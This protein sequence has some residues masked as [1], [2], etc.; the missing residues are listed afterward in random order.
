MKKV[1]SSGV[2]GIFLL[3]LMFSAGFSQ[4]ADSIIAK[5]LDAQGGRKLL[6][7]IKDSTSH[8]EKDLPTMGITGTVIMYVK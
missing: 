7:S 1:L 2:L 8:A 6:E 5:M 3:G 4:D